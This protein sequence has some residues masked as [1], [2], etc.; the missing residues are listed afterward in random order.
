MTN[1]HVMKPS[2]RRVIVSITLVSILS[3]ILMGIFL[4]VVAIS[5]HK[6]R[7]PVNAGEY[8]GLF[9]VDVTIWGPLF[10][11]TLWQATIPVVVALGVL[12]AWLRKAPKK[13]SPTIR[14]GVD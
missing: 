1:I 14:S 6:D 4:Y 13:S 5:G 12:A 2:L 3:C 10:L 9:V 11:L 8:V 7:S